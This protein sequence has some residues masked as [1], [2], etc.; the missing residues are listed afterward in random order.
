MAV[1]AVPG[2]GDVIRYTISPILSRLAWPLLMR[3]IFGPQPVPAKFAGFPKA[4]AVRPSQL[5]ASAAESGLMVPDALAAHDTYAWLKMPVAII[6]G[7]DDRLVNAKEQSARLHK[8]MPQSSFL[9]VAGAGHMIHQ[10]TTEAV[11]PRS[12][13][14]LRRRLKP[15]EPGPSVQGGRTT[16]FC[17]ALR[18]A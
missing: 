9:C 11:C 5:R 13:R 6:A 4:L 17:R 7:A 1:P 16:Y 2:V 14:W 10:T 8:E 18:S 3:K 12:R 15:P